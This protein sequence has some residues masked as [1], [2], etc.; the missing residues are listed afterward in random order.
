MVALLLA[1]IFISSAD[2]KIFPYDV[3]SIATKIISSGVPLLFEKN[4]SN[5]FALFSVVFTIKF[6]GNA[7]FEI[8]FSPKTSPVIKI[9]NYAFDSRFQLKKSDI[10]RIRL[11]LSFVN[12][13]F[14]IN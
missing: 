8:T 10:K 13:Y 9:S 6:S 2:E 4:H 3:P 1:I 7:E 14:R 11:H 5:R 12:K